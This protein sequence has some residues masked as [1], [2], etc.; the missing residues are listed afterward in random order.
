MTDPISCEVNQAAQEI[1]KEPGEEEAERP[2][3]ERLLEREGARQGQ[4][5]SRR[6]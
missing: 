4:G 6:P 1:G 5:T 3:G 2:E